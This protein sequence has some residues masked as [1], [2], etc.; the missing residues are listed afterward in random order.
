MNELQK[1]LELLNSQMKDMKKS[2]DEIQVGLTKEIKNVLA[3]VKIN[4]CM[5]EENFSFTENRIEEIE[6]KVDTNIGKS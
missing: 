5:I 2:Y 6:N 4:Q 1:S 3:K